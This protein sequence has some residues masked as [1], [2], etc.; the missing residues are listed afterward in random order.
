MRAQQLAQKTLQSLG[1]TFDN[2]LPAEVQQCVMIAAPHTSNW[3][4]LYT[5]LAFIVMNIPVKITIKDSYLKPPFGPFVRAM[6]GI[7]INRNPRQTGEQRPS[8]VQAMADLFK[9]HPRLVMLVTPEG[10]RSLQPKWKTGFYHVAVQAGVP[11]ALAYLDYAKK[12]AGVGKIIY[13]SGDIAKDMQEIMAF[14]ATIQGKHPER[15]CLDQSHVKG[16]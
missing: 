10:T 6:G 13:P 11:I 1:W 8:M 5:K 7:G 4:S 14:Y 12:E 16:D 15:F 2:H 3:D 9:T